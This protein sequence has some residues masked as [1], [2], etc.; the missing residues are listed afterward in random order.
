MAKFYIFPDAVA[1][2]KKGD[3]FKLGGSE[4]EVTD[5]R[6]ARTADLAICLA[7]SIPLILPDNK[8][9]PCSGCG[10]ALQWRPTLPPKLK[11]CCIRCAQIEMLSAEARDAAEAAS[12]SPPITPVKK[13]RSR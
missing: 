2:A 4:F 10:D 1:G 5:G 3:V 12:G 7:I 11:R 8:T 9:G 6:K 13:K